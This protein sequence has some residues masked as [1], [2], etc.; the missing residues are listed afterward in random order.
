MSPEEA[1]PLQDEVLAIAKDA[2]ADIAPLVDELSSPTENVLRK[3]DDPDASWNL[4]AGIW[5]A[6]AAELQTRCE[7]YERVIY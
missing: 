4:N 3:A 7:P 1:R 6:A 5:T 2:P